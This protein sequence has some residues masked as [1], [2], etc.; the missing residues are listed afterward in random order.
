MIEEGT[1]MATIK[2]VAKKAGVAPSTVSRALHDSSL[3]SKS[4]KQK[5]W[6]AMDALNYSPNFAAQNLANNTSNIIGVILPPNKESVANNPF[7][8]QILQGIAAVC[9]QQ[10]FMVAIA[11]G[12]NDDELI[13]NIKMMIKRGKVNKFIITYSQKNGAVIQFLQAQ[14]TECVLIGEP[15]KNSSETLFVNNDNVQA[16]RDATEFLFNQ[17]FQHPVFVYNDL[18]EMVQRDRYVGYSQEVQKNVEDAVGFELDREHGLEQLQEF[19]KQHP[20]VD[21]FVVCDDIMAITLQ[22]RLSALEQKTSDFGIISFNNSIFARAMH[23]ALT[24]VEIFPSSLGMEAAV[25][26][27]NTADDDFKKLRSSM[28]HVIIPH[29]IIAR[30]STIKH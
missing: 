14:H 3:I 30:E 17:G 5:I 2:D 4:T 29:K 6:D 21:S 28:S 24:S 10:D 22:N 20:R 16:G 19:L 1:H 11:T 8:S 26:I 7:F 12:K 18:T 23:P 15:A 9:N 25:L 13:E 27:L